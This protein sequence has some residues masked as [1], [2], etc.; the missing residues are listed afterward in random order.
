[1]Q[2]LKTWNVAAFALNVAL[3]VVTGYLFSSVVP[4]KFEGV[5]FW[6]QVIVPAVFAAVFGPWVGGLGAAL[7][8]FLNDIILGNN[9]LL[10]LMA[11]VTSNFACFWLI[12]YIMNK[13]TRWRV[14]VV[15]SGVVSAL[16]IGL[17]LVYIEPLL[18]I[19][20]SIAI[21]ASYVVLVA[22]ALLASRWRSYEVGS[23]I[24]LLVGSAI[25]GVTVP[26]YGQ[27]FAPAVTAI[28]VPLILST[29]AFTFSSEIPFLLILGPPIIEAVHR[30]FPNLKTKEESREHQ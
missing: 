28:T 2:Q 13:R 22:V 5:R 24:G 30:A 8:I 20:C 3:Y 26:L 4:I 1:V 12:G 7:G 19:I 14:S 17:A 25:I 27:Y 16:L 10:S 18:G 11:G 23:V 9:P 15:A 6:P 21:A 29:F